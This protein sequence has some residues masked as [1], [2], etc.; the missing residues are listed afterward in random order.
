MSASDGTVRAFTRTPAGEATG[1]RAASARY[2]YPINAK[3]PSG[4]LT[5]SE[6]SGALRFAGAA[7]IG[8]IIATIVLPG[9]LAGVGLGTG[10]LI[11]LGDIL[12][13]AGTV[14]SVGT[15]LVG[16]FG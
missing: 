14:Y 16:C 12:G 5:Q 3:D 10:A 4:L 2:Y 7:V 13:V 8:T 9:G 6:C 11:M 1:V 15:A